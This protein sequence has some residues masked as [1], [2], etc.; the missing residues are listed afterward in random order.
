MDL[1]NDAVGR[2]IA[3]DDP[4]ASEASLFDRVMRAHR[5]GE[6]LTSLPE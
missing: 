4:D 2:R 1:H 6:L 5:R 3:L